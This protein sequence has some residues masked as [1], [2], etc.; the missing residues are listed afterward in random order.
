MAFSSEN[1]APKT[2]TVPFCNPQPAAMVA[3]GGWL[4]EREEHRAVLQPPTR[5]HGFGPF[6]LGARVINV[7]ELNTVVFSISNNHPACAFSVWTKFTV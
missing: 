7:E 3:K 6:E 5:S 4:I 2:S 1:A